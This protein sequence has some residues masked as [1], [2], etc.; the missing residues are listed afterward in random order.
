MVCESAKESSMSLSVNSSSTNNPYLLSLL[1]QGSPFG[2]S[3]S[4]SDPLSALFAAL[5]QQG[6]AAT[7]TGTASS[8][9]GA[10]AA[11]G[12]TPQF[13][14]Q[15]LQ[16]LF[17]MQA[18]ASN[19]QSLTSQ[20][21]GA[22]DPTAAANSTDPSQQAQ[23]SEQGHH[24]H[25]HHHQMA[26]AG[27]QNPLDMLASQAGGA[28]SQTTANSNGSSTTTITYADGST[29]ALTT[30]ASSSS[31]SSS[32]TSSGGSNAASNNLMEQ[33]IQIQAQLLSTTPQSIATV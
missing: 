33:L 8:S 18:N 30:P 32:A 4:Q 28:S 12:S 20:F 29:V 15:T 23:Q 11:S 17:A 13:G 7:A 27:D 24:G 1:Q 26:G 21:D 5:G 10:T 25:H 16:A 31:S 6:A 9:A 19:S 2:S 22:T 14:P 3:A